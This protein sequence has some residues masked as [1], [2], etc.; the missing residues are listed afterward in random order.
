[1]TETIPNFNLISIQN[2]A[3]FLRK[4]NTDGTDESGAIKLSNDCIDGY[5]KTVKELQQCENGE[6][7]IALENLR[8]ETLEHFLDTLDNHLIYDFWKWQGQLEQ[9]FLTKKEVLKQI[10]EYMAASTITGT[11]E[12]DEPLFQ[13]DSNRF[14]HVWSKKKYRR[15]LERFSLRDVKDSIDF[16]GLTECAETL[17]ALDKKLTGDTR[18]FELLDRLRKNRYDYSRGVTMIFY[19]SRFK[20]QMHKTGIVPNIADLVISKLRE[21]HEIKLMEEFCSDDLN[22]TE[23]YELVSKMSDETVPESNLHVWK[24]KAK[25]VIQKFQTSFE[26]FSRI[27]SWHEIETNELKLFQAVEKFRYTLL[28]ITRMVF[29]CDYPELWDDYVK[30]PSYQIGLALIDELW[31]KKFYIERPLLMHRDLGSLRDLPEL[32]TWG[33]TKEFATKIEFLKLTPLFNE[34][35]DLEARSRELCLNSSIPYSHLEEFRAIREHSAIFHH[36]VVTVRNHPSLEE[37]EEMMN[38]IKALKGESPQS[39]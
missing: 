25:E 9:T 1:M 30:K 17:L 22:H 12:E 38:E 33:K 36:I 5:E 20:D 6:T 26:Q 16:L 19:H 10:P 31:E 3:S 7:I 11:D 18:E 35:V 14:G 23:Y 39:E 15:L 2:F 34:I 24:G 28:D 27:E 29:L 21:Q 13:T 8:N 4:I 32:L 37:L